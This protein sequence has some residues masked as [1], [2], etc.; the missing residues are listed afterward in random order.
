MRK[1]P[2]WVGGIPVTTWLALAE[3]ICAA[4]G[5]TFVQATYLCD[6]EVTSGP[7]PIHITLTTD[8]ELRGRRLPSIWGNLKISGS[9]GG[10]GIR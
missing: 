9:C 8:I 6:P 2:D 5:T 4:Q 3:A 7:T 10:K 1:E